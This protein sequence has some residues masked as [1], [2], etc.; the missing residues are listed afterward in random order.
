LSEKAKSSGKGGIR[1]CLPVILESLKK[2][3]DI[4]ALRDTEECRHDTLYALKDILHDA[5]LIFEEE[6][7]WFYTWEKER[8]ELLKDYQEFE[9][10]DEY[11]VKLNHSKNL[12]EEVTSKNDPYGCSFDTAKWQENDTFKYF[13]QHLQTGYPDIYDFWKEM[14]LHYKNVVDIFC[15]F[16][17]EIEE[18]ALKRGFKLIKLPHDWIPHKEGKFVYGWRI[19]NLKERILQIPFG[20]DDDVMQPL[21]KILKYLIEPNGCEDELGDLIND[22]CCLE[23]MNDLYWEFL[24]CRGGIDLD[25]SSF[26]MKVWPLIMGVR[27]NGEPL[28]GLCDRCPKVIIGRGP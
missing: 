1:K 16:Y 7:K 15:E 20:G 19:S 26:L 22:F 25:H 18:I 24:N 21:E 23:G 14:E 11:L 9:N 2:G 4:E 17:K 13:L 8:E 27:E 3:M 5:K 6:G 28:R 12:I 10:M